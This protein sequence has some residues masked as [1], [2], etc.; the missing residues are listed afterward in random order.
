M[1]IQQIIKN[2]LINEC[3]SLE[4]KIERLIQ[5]NQSLPQSGIKDQ[6]Y[7]SKQI[8]DNNKIIDESNEKIKELKERIKKND[9]GDLDEKIL[10]DI[11]E[12][13]NKVRIKEKMLIK[14]QEI[15]KEQYEK[16]KK[17]FEESHRLERKLNYSQKQL[18][19]EMKKEAERFATFEIPDYITENLKGMPNNKGYIWKGMWCFG[20]LPPEND[21]SICIMFEKKRD[22]M[23]IHEIY[24]RER[25]IYMKENNRQKEYL[26]T[27]RRRIIDQSSLFFDLSAK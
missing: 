13:T 17:K 2:T 8:S 18:N 15:E 24:P 1:S 23:Y 22:V 14:K 6:S 9:R 5:T 19:Y 21:N 12:T 16:Q 26:K 11:E 20:E 25:V 7:V 4:K 27:I 10:N 3:T